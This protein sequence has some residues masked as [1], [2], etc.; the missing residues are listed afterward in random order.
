MV[1]TS[2]WCHGCDV[3]IYLSLSSVNTVSRRLQIILPQQTQRQATTVATITGALCSQ[4]CIPTC[5]NPATC[6]SIWLF[7]MCYHT[8]I[9]HAIVYCTLL[10]WIYH[11]GSGVW[12][13]LGSK[14]PLFCYRVR[15]NCRYHCSKLWCYCCLILRTNSPSHTS[16]KSLV[17]VGMSLYSWPT[18]T[19]IY[20]QCWSC[21]MV[22]LT[23]AWLDCKYPT[24]P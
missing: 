15:R 11:S 24:L 22:T 9:L 3:I 19:C 10:L 17:L 6:N 14:V 21:I 2:L 1:N 12:R 5:K 16:E 8:C 23:V 13:N 7:S 4:G 20:I 18:C